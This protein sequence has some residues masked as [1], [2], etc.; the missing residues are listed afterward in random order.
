MDKP[1][2]SDRM[3]WEIQPASFPDS[4]VIRARLR[5]EI[6]AI[7]LAIC[8][9]KLRLLWRNI[10]VFRASSNALDRPS[11]SQRERVI[12]R[13][14]GKLSRLKRHVDAAVA[15]MGG[16]EV[17][18]E[19]R[20]EPKA[21]A[22]VELHN[23]LSQASILLAAVHKPAPKKPRSAFEEGRE[24]PIKKG[25]IARLLTA[26]AL[27]MYSRLD[28]GEPMENPKATGRLKAFVTA[29]FRAAGQDIGHEEA[30]EK[31][32]E[33]VTLQSRFPFR[34]YRRLRLFHLKN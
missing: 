1:S 8:E 25:D 34:R 28:H 32:R 18:D 11:A 19:L 22:Y 2:R 31:I 33:A 9:A 7:G 15:A 20:L 16:D 24:G 12:G 23:V 6:E 13:I 4:D 29:V 5:T 3:D 26:D 14:E 30:R 17:Y 21:A 27:F 10:R